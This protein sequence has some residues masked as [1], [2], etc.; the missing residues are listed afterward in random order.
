MPYE[1]L[2]SLAGAKQ[3]PEFERRWLAVI[4]QPDAD[5]GQLLP[6]VDMVVKRGG[7]AL[8][9]TLAWTWL[10]TVKESRT[11]VEALGLGRDLV[12]R[13]PEGGELRGEILSL[14]RQVHQDRE[15]LDTW[16]DRSGLQTGKSVRRALRFLETGLRLAV[17]TF[18]IHRTED[19]AAEIT[20][21]DL[22]ADLVTVKTIRGGQDFEI[23]RLIEEYD[24]AEENDFRIL[25][26]LHP[27]RLTDLVQ[28]DPV[29]LAVGVLRSRGDRLDRDELKLLLV[30]RCL[31]AEKWSDWWAKVRTG[32]KRSPNLRIEGR[33]PMFLIYDEAG[34]SLEEEVWAAF[35]K[36]GTPRQWLDLLQGYLRDAKHRKTDPNVEFV[37]RV[38]R[39]LVDRIDRFIRHK[40]RASAF[41]TALVIERVAADGLPVS[42]DAHG[43][44]LRMLQEADDPVMVAASVPETRLW[45]LATSCVEQ[46]FPEKWPELFAKLILHAPAGQCET[47]AKKVEAAGRA[48]VLPS[49]VERATADPERHLGAMTWV[50]NGPGVKTT[51]PIPPLLELLNIILGLVGPPRASGGQTAGPEVGELRSKI[52]AGLASRNYARY[53]QCLESLDEPMAQTVRRQVERAEGLGPRV[54][55]S[56][57]NILRRRFPKLYVKAKVAMWDDESVLYFTTAGLRAKEA[58]LHELVNVKMR[59]N[60][61]AIGEAAAR[62]DL[63]ENSE[64]KCAL[65]ERDLLRARVAQINSELSLAKVLDPQAVPQD[66]VSIGQRVTLRPTPG[67]EPVIMTIL[68]IGDSDITNG[69][70]SYQA[71][72]VRPALGKRIGEVVRISFDGQEAEYEIRQIEQAIG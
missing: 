7:A 57:L 52:R 3:W 1:T 45:P 67:G 21:F 18:L 55:D 6:I 44:A 22:Q 13:L 48:D 71:P 8:A 4:E 14:Y 35:I 40:D 15:D 24:L 64:Y 12:Q 70:Y 39:A 60:A 43:L 20:A 53:R 33:S 29:A 32:V 62:G 49:I 46:A 50:W 56:M 31:P 72:L 58:A 41:A 10:S 28:K 34:Q 30:P 61:K 16:I 2:R 54:Q 66:H 36:A 9:E 23:A 25:T 38:Q 26:Q 59:E 65:E 27:D 69:V 47:L 11:P 37:E 51:L 63:S 68:G 5:A 19:V 17:G 42:A